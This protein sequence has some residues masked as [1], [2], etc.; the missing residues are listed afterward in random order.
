MGSLSEILADPKASQ[1]QRI[2]AA[3]D[4][5]GFQPNRAEAVAEILRYITPQTSPELA[6]GLL[7]TVK[8]STAKESASF[9]VDAMTTSSPKVKRS[10]IAMLLSKPTWAA[11]LLDAVESDVLDLGELTLDQKQ[12]L[13]LL[14][15]AKMRSRAEELFSR[16]DGL[17]NPNR[18][19]VL[20]SLMHLT[21]S[22][23]DAGAGKE[24]FK[25]ACANCHQHGNLGQKVG[26][27]LT[28]MA[29][30]PKDELL[31]HIID[32]S[33]NVEGNFRLY[34]LLTLDGVVVNGMLADESKTS[35][36]II[37]AQGKRT[38]LQ[39]VDI[40]Q[41]VA[42]RKSVMPEGFEK[43]LNEQELTDLLEFLTDTGPFVPLPL[44]DVATAISTKGLFHDGD[45]GPD[46]MVFS[47]W[48]N[49]MVGNVPFLLVDP[50]GQSKKNIVLL[51][52][53]HG[54]LPPKMP[55]SV[56][57]PFGAPAAAVHLLSGV[58]GWNHP[59]DQR[60]TISM[61][62]RLTYRD[63][64]VEDH[65]LRNGEHFADYIRRIDVPGSEFAFA[66]GEQQIRYLKVTPKF[67]KPIEKIELVKGED[68]S[69]P[70]VMA[71]TVE[72][73]PEHKRSENEPA[74]STANPD[75]E[76]S[77][78]FGVVLDPIRFGTITLT[79]PLPKNGT[80]KKGTTVTVH[81][82]PDEGYALDSIYYSV[83][84]RWGAMYHESLTPEFRIKIDQ[85][86]HIGASFIRSEEVEHIDV[87]HNIVYAQPGKKPLKYDVYSPKGASGIP[88]IAIIHGG[89]WSANDEN[90][91][92]G[93]ARELTRGGKFVV[94]SIDYRWIDDFDGD[95]LPNT[96]ADLIE[97]V[98]G[99]VVHIMHHAAKYGGDAS[100]IGVTGDSAG[101]HLSASI[102][103][104]VERVGSG[105]FG[106]SNEVYEYEPTF[107]PPGV[108]ADDMRRKL[109]H[110]IRA[111]APSYGVFS[112][113]LLGRF[114]RGMTPSASRATAPLDNIPQ[115]TERSVPQYLTRGKKDSLIKDEEV[116]A[117]AEALRTRGQTVV[118]DQIE[119][120]GH[121]FFDWKP[122]DK[123]KATFAEHGV[124]WAAKM[125][126][127]FE[128][129]LISSDEGFPSTP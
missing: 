34:S 38:D 106:T 22:S 7:Q 75:T 98:F 43:Q 47:D 93:L 128:E 65:D 57:L 37:D 94:C 112:T 100:R 16:R 103:T 11:S 84:G 9:L 108:S 107:L 62:V 67:D 90:V 78:T 23:G 114:T 89:G 109:S 2:A 52:G 24:A 88:I 102:A 120:A 19:K 18:E 15:D 66:L 5:V 118:Y 96:M 80:Y 46:R 63:G 115:A 4:L 92:R 70:I 39:R 64:L 27:N 85:E 44:D 77:E 101:G 76:A 104:M 73:L 30:H 26:P 129:H 3:R 83:P 14:P 8:L 56:S 50:N 6:A 86:K 97:D 61:T 121:A 25:K 10:M 74:A 17:P 55:R 69:A 113:G 13:R 1:E 49:K 124:P 99:A 126:S 54:S 58:G 28:G 68:K 20:Q 35:V 105:G 51:N 41:M 33:R 45:S 31:T 32:P 48:G 91:M 53:P 125:R 79:P 81:A 111:A 29:A 59:H 21:R 95:D 40:E 87:L 71:V 119:N 123:V 116:A 72:R 36:T 82:I 42:S 122:N 117:Y 12:A 127:F 110:A 60:P